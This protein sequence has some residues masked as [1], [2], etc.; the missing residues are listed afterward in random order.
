MHK[1]LSPLLPDLATQREKCEIAVEAVMRYQYV[2]HEPYGLFVIVTDPKQ[3]NSTLVKR[4]K[5]REKLVD[6]LC[7]NDDVSSDDEH[8]LREL[9]E[10]MNVMY[11]ELYP[12]PSSF[13]ETA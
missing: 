4:F 8:D 3:I 9:H 5:K 7:L 1:G 10:A 11:S 6:Q 2:V 13:E 12:T